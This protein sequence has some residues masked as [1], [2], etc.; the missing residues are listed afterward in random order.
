MGAAASEAGRPLP[1][2]PFARA[3]PGSNPDWLGSLLASLL[4]RASEL[5]L[6][7]SGDA[8][9][10]LRATWQSVFSAFLALLQQHLRLLADARRAGGQGAGSTSTLPEGAVAALAC[11]PLVRVTLP[12][13]TEAQQQVLR[14]FIAELRQ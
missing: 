5:G 13:C 4:L 14:N 1:L 2:F 9:G 3:P 11:M 8:P 7:Q 10:E 12:H 6:D